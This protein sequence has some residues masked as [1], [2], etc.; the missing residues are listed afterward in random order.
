MEIALN[1]S[2]KINDESTYDMGL[3]IPT[4]DL[5]PENPFVFKVQDKY[6]SNGKEVE[7]SVLQLAFADSNHIY[8]E[9][10]PP[11]DLLETAGLNDYIEELNAV[12]KEGEYKDGKFLGQDGSEA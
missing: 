6:L 11:K 7:A 9:V 2:I 5:S 8:L 3:N 10:A 12:I 4:G 1:V